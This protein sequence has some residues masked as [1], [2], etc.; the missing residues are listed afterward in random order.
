MQIRQKAGFLIFSLAMACCSVLSAQ[1]GGGPVRLKH[2]LPNVLKVTN[3]RVYSDSPT[4]AKI[5]IWLE[6][7]K[8]KIVSVSRGEGEWLI[9][10]RT[11]GKVSSYLVSE[12][13]FK[14]VGE[15]TKSVKVRAIHFAEGE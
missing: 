2:G 14:I 10:V 3:V 11:R 15:E 1:E 13:S 9:T 7:K 12:K 4:S 6:V 5:S 8:G